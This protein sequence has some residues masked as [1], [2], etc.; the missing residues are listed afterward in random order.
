MKKTTIIFDFDGTIVDSLSLV[1]K[2]ANQLLGKKDGKTQLTADIIAELR[3]K[4]ARDVLKTL[5]LPVW[6]VPF[7]LFK[8]KKLFRQDIAS[9]ACFPH[10]AEIIKKLKEKGL[11]LGILSSN[12]EDIIELFLKNNAIQDF[13]FV[14]SERN[15]FGKTKALKNLLQRY[16]LRQDEVLYVGDEVRDIEACKSAGVEVVA[17][18]WGFNSRK[19]LEL[20][21]PDYIVDT[22]EE[23]LRLL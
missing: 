12:S 5:S 16:H 21:T 23:L 7:L 18:T 6:K 13:S 2:I 1:V 4:S 14:H 11:R 9:V 10:L 8:G 20:N 22:P 17:V 19:I 3:N 15:I